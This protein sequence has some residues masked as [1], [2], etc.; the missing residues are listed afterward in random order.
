M[1]LGTF[2][3]D[4]SKTEESCNSEESSK[5]YLSALSLSDVTFSFLLSSSFSL[6]FSSF[7]RLSDIGFL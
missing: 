2:N 3:E 4:S 7:Y 1:A 6:S 5:S